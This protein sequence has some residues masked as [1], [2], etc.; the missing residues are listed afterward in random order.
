MEGGEGATGGLYKIGMAAAPRST[1]N[2]P[3]TGHRVT[4]MKNLFGLK[5]PFNT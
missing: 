1:R 5:A 3:C 4:V 2:A